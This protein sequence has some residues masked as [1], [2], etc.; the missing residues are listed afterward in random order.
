VTTGDETRRD[1]RDRAVDALVATYDGQAR[2][3]DLLDLWQQRAPMSDADVGLA[4]ELAL[5][6]ARRRI[7]CEH[8]ASHFYRGRWAG[9]RDKLRVILAVGVYQLCWLDRVPD[10]AAIDQTVRQS[11]KL[12]VGAAKIANAVLRQVQR[13]RGEPVARTDEL[14][15][16]KTLLLDA[17]RQASFSTDVFP[18]PLR[19]PLNYYE[20]AYGL[21]PWL[22]ERWHRIFKPAGCR[23]I[24]EATIHRP[25]LTLRPNP[26]KTTAND[27]FAMLAERG[28]NPARSDDGDSILLDSTVSVASVPEIGEGLCQP[29]D[30]TAQ[31]ALRHAELKPG[32]FVIDY[33]AG[34]GTKSTQAAELLRNEGRV[35]A[36]DIEAQKLERLGDA[37]KRHGIDI[38]ET[39]AIHEIAARIRD[40]NRAPDVILIDAPCTNTGVLARRPEARYRA[41]QQSL[42]ELT[43][44]Q[45]EILRQ[46]AALAGPSTRLVYTTC[47]LER[48][49]NERQVRAFLKDDSTWKLAGEQM[50]LPNGS[51]NGGFWARLEKHPSET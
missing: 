15:A 5:G 22:I 26:L 20:T 8:I 48:E 31:Q 18:D 25:G 41:N 38:I 6:V 21:P 27:L 4:R 16:R 28:L 7:T 2:C 1:A 10:H 39:C 29:Q 13:H 33:C 43:A 34:V 46:A 35:I 17:N 36:T 47:S 9:L 23:Q 32:M 42:G 19:K 45:G 37:A 12:G 3:T 11:K 49:E 44:I 50:T 24:C 40:A 51:Q 30:E 14:D